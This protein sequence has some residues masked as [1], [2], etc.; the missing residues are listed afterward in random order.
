MGS[1]TR[2]NMGDCF[3]TRYLVPILLLAS[4]VASA[5][6]SRTILVTG[7][8]GRTGSQ[9]YLALQKMPGLTVRA[10]IRN[11]TK[12]QIVLNCSK[13]DAS[14][15]IYVGDVTTP[16]DKGLGEALSGT[17]SLVITTGPAFHCTLPKVY[18]GCK[19]YPGADPKTMSWLAVKNQVATFAKSTGPSLN[20]KHVV[21]LS[22]DMTT[23][24]DNMLD[25]VGNG[26]G[27]FYSLNGEAFT[28]N[29]G[30]QFTIIKPNGLGDGE[31][32]AQELVVAHDDAG[33]SPTD[34]NYEF[35]SRSDVARMLTYAVSHPN[36]T[37]GLRFD[38]TANKKGT[39]PTKD[40]SSLFSQAMYP[41]DPRH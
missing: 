3:N 1:H 28:M 27:C 26:H 13:C 40:I 33:W 32:G 25:K 11:V 41:W 5:A 2:A 4:M 7:A 21:L 30:V 38:V 31:P 22:N 10:L 20:S 39:T 16:G 34:L 15:G 9:V 23:T 6:P 36:V 8:T 29:S 37:T 12:A 35:I 24:P 17:E 14:E 19:F 18:I